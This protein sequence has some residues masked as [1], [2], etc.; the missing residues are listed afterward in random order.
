MTRGVRSPRAGWAILLG[1]G[2]VLLAAG[3]SDQARLSSVDVPFGVTTGYVWDGHE[4]EPLAGVEVYSNG[5]LSGRTD[6]KGYYVATA[7]YDQVEHWQ[8]AFVKEGYKARAF[9][10]PDAGTP[11]TQDPGAYRLDVVLER[12]GGGSRR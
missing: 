4:G 8:I 6:A 9:T 5:Q 12:E 2:L 7:G 3:C 10:M 1:S 11:D